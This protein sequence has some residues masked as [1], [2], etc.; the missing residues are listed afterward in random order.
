[1]RRSQVNID[2]LEIHLRHVPLHTA[3]SALSG[4]GQAVLQRIAEQPGMRL[5]K[6]AIRLGSLA[7]GTMQ[8][9]GNVSP[10]QLAS[11]IA[12]RVAQAVA[13]KIT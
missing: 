4:L 10:A 9:A 11:L 2:R 3:R 8:T 7:L 12:G 5:E 6:G 13:E 1:M